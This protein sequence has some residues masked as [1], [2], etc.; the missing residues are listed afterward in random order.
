M[1]EASCKYRINLNPYIFKGIIVT[2][3]IKLVEQPVGSGK[4][5]QLINHVITTGGLVIYCAP[6][7][8]L[9]KQIHADIGSRINEE[10]IKL[11]L[12][13]VTG[14]EKGFNNT[15]A[16]RL[17]ELIL[18][19]EANSVIVCTIEGFERVGA[20]VLKQATEKMAKT[21]SIIID[22]LPNLFASYNK[23]FSRQTIEIIRPLIEVAPDGITYVLDSTLDEAVR[24]NLFSDEVERLLALAHGQT[25]RV[26]K[27][28]DDKWLFFGYEIKE[29]L[30]SLIRAADSVYILAATIKDTLDYI[31]LKDVWGF[32]LESCLELNGQI[33]ENKVDGKTG[34]IRV[35]PLL[36]D[37]FSRGK[38]TDNYKPLTPTYKSC[39]SE[40]IDNSISFIGDKYALMIGNLWSNELIKYHLK[41][42][43]NIELLPPNVKGL[44]DYKDS[45]ICC[46]IYSS[47][48]NGYIR[49]SLNLMKDI[50]GL[51]SNLVSAY[52]LQAELD[53][54]VQM[55]GRTSIRD[56]DST[57]MN[58]FLV[59]DEEQ[60]NHVIKTYVGDT[61][62]YSSLIDKSLM[63][64]W[65]KYTSTKMGKPISEGRLEKAQE[66]AD[67]IEDMKAN[68]IKV[69][70]KDAAATFNIKYSSTLN[71]MFKDIDY[72]YKS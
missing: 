13:Q 31:V 60:A 5:Y 50:H 71:R 4:T 58:H 24:K 26:E 47:K 30:N 7:K 29:N 8:N 21:V 10:G 51:E 46:A 67:Y 6:T 43:S 68:G 62:L 61:G 48:P 37:G 22:E 17:E 32:K 66:I 27:V 25:V 23:S 39:L 64:N 49:N 44:N 65:S 14:E 28:S 36:D 52:T 41:G 20:T 63:V 3:T 69:K 1:V 38:A 34:N 57:E 11:E 33:N 55:C 40:M 12:Y 2:D 9:V 53:M 56:R 72:C 70:L 18:D 19:A 54:I 16:D 42:I 15:V 35:Y 59:A 45:H